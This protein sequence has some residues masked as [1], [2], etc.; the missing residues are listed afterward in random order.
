MGNIYPQINLRSKNE[1]A[2]RIS[3]KGFTRQEA[4]DLINDVLSHKDNYWYD[5]KISQPDKGKFIR[6]CVGM[7][8]GQLLK[9][10]D[11]QILKPHDDKLPPFIFGGVS[12]LN[13]VLAA[14]NLIGVKKQ[15]SIISAD[16]SKFF[17]QIS[18]ERVFYFFIANVDVGKGLQKS[19]QIFVVCLRAQNYLMEQSLF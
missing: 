4:L 1:I 2:K 5:S 14:K 6:S 19:W 12:G 3:Y 17:E 18:E 15:R 10:I 16:V 13:H 8:L 11:R 9:I 7:P